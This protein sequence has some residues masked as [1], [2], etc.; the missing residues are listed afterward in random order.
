MHLYL[1]ENFLHFSQRQTETWLQLGQLNLEAFSPGMTG[2]LH[3]VHI[4]SP[5]DFCDKP[6]RAGRG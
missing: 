5:I 2:L 3:D 1:R 6:S 4:G